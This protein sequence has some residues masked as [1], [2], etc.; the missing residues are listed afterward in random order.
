MTI[1]LALTAWLAP[2]IVIA[3]AV[4]AAVLHDRRQ[5]RRDQMALA[6]LG[7]PDDRDLPLLEHIARRELEPFFTAWD[8]LVHQETPESMS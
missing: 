1:L 3:A 6:S 2:S 8:A 4:L 7:E 5:A